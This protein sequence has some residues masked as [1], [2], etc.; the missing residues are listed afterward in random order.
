MKLPAERAALFAALS[1]LTK[2]PSLLHPSAVADRLVAF[3]TTFYKD[4]G[5]SPSPEAL[6]MRVGWK[7]VGAGLPASLWGQA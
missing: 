2:A 1:A 4:E 5:E 3:M 7:W 6:G